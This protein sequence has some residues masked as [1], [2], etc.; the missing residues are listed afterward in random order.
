MRDSDL[1]GDNNNLFAFML[2]V[3]E[4]LEKPFADCFRGEFTVLQLNVLCMLCTQGPMTVTELAA[5]L[6]APRQ[7]ISKLVE[8]L[9]EEGRIIRNPDRSDRRRVLISVEENTFRYIHAKREVFLKLF[10]RS[11]ERM[12]G[13]E[14][15]DFL[16][17]VETINSVLTK[18][19]QNAVSRER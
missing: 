2:Y 12:D 7:Q 13:K 10:H 15:S 4:T 1:N 6:H 19:S 17:A 8:K 14:F 11:M 18:I 9:D 3:N 16:A 5:L